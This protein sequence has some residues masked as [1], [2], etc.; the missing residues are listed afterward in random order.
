VRDIAITRRNP[1]PIQC[2]FTTDFNI[3]ILAGQGEFALS[4][5]CRS[6]NRWAYF[7]RHN[8][9]GILRIMI[10]AILL[11]ASSFLAANPYLQVIQNAP[12][13]G[14]LCREARRQLNEGKYEEAREAAN[15]ALNMNARSAEA[16]SLLG[17]SEFGLG[18][19]TAAEHHLTVALSFDASLTEAHRALGATFLQEQRFRFAEAQFQTVLQSNPNDIA[20]LYG[21]GFSLLVRNKPSQA[22]NP[23]LKANRLDPSS[24]GILT[25]LLEVYLKLERSSQAG[26]I[27]EEL[28]RQIANDYSQQMQLAK[29]LVREGAF[30][31]A[32]TQFER[33][34]KMRPASYELNYDLALA[35]HRAGR[36]D[37]AATQIH[38]MLSQHDNAELQNLLG[39]VEE[40]RHNYP[41]ALA[42]YKKATELQPK[43]EEYQL[44]YATELALHWNPSDALGAFLAGVKAFPNS[45]TLWMGLGGCY[46][47]LGKYRQAA[48]TLLHTSQ[49]APDNGNV[50]ALLG[51]AYDAA[52]SLQSDVAKRF[53]DYLKARPDDAR[54]HYFYG[55]ILLGQSKE[56]SEKDF[57]R[58]KQEFVKAIA[59]DPS[60][61]Q[62]RLELGELLRM[63]GDLPAARAQL[64]AAV[65]LDPESSDAY[66][67]LMGIYRKLGEQR[68]ADLALQKFRKLK[69]QSGEKAN[70]VQVMTLLGSGA[71]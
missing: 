35:Y 70:R 20:S 1:G 22:L 46:Y 4:K 56:K 61:P 29:V 49:L 7:L 19:L 40:K 62:A 33:L 64:E 18:N 38:R 63:Q 17:Q 14:E 44:D 34:L 11:L 71:K 52:G 12:T 27:L 65:E 55:K 39:E 3:L 16:Q 13:I 41:Q 21:L 2:P 50:Y 59:L 54:A 68:K 26:P 53:E 10:H 32:I 31:L 69:D 28:N 42:A 37:R 58:A 9:R 30:D 6:P 23:L 67:Q 43:S 36:D 60:L 47:L 66:Y 8:L 15:K 25:A 24:S 5:S 45:A 57:S 48:E 51:L